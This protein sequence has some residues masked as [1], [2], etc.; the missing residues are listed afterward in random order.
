[1]PL[2][3]LAP[4]SFPKH[5]FG[6]LEATELLSFNWL[7]LHTKPRAEKKLAERLFQKQIG[8]F[9]PVFNRTWRHNGR[10]L[11]SHLPLFP[12][13]LFLL[14]DE[15]NERKFSAFSTGLVAGYL[16]V[17]DQT[18]LQ[19]ELAQIHQLIVSEVPLAPEDRLGPGKPVEIVAGPLKGMEGIIV[20]RNASL[21][22]VVQVDFIQ[23]GASVEVE[24]W[25]VRPLIPSAAEAIMN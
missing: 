25:M 3:P 19:R 7:V 20:R 16:P 1:M 11:T 13:Y 21:R 4:Y 12:G 23:R 9:L 10:R 5:L 18:R 6:D 22:F 2:L 15:L 17:F 14:N 24:S 8:F